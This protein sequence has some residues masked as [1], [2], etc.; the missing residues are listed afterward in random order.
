MNYD[1]S[2]RKCNHIGFKTNKK[3]RNKA[4]PDGLYCSKHTTQL[5]EPYPME[6]RVDGFYYS[7]NTNQLD[8]YSR[9]SIIPSNNS[10]TGPSKPFNNVSSNPSN[11]SNNV[12]SNPSNLSNNVSSILSNLSNNVSSIPSNLS[13]NV[14]SIPSNYVSSN[15]S[16]HSHHVSSNPS[17][18]SQHSHHV[19][20][21]PSNIVS[22]KPSNPSNN[23]SS[24]PSDYS[25]YLQQ[26]SLNKI[27]SYV[28]TNK[29][30]YDGFVSKYKN[31]DLS[32]DFIG[33]AQYKPGT[34]DG[35]IKNLIDNNVKLYITFNNQGNFVEITKKEEKLFNNYCNM[36]GCKYYSLKVEDYTPPE[37]DI[38]KNLWII[39]DDFH[40][41]KIKKPHIQCIMHCT[42]GLGRTGTMI[43]S[44]IVYRKFLTDKKK[45][46]EELFKLAESIVDFDKKTGILNSKVNTPYMHMK[47]QNYYKQVLNYG[48]IKFAFDEIKK[49]SQHS[50]NEIT[51]EMGESIKKMLLFENRIKNIILAILT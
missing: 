45:Y 35:C 32:I 47:H 9:F 39:L 4:R 38:L 12:S 30:N 40:K 22:S 36:I 50:F 19:S 43:F 27:K 28:K 51:G 20:S 37:I 31:D 17:H 29:C 23:V 49:Y 25:D 1:D 13:N 15:P 16:H 2:R 3:C 34:L 48:I 24:K 6:A 11:L 14:S 7:K 10:N 46:S 42:A 41:E 26:E 44:Y 5:D 21:N 18:H 33:L 8:G